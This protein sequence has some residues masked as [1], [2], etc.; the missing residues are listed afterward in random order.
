MAISVAMISLEAHTSAEGEMC[1][2]M[3]I[4]LEIDS[5][6]FNRLIGVLSVLRKQ[7]NESQ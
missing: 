7:E 4:L 6:L 3:R 2:A 5:R 1:F